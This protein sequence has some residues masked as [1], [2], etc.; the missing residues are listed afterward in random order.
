MLFKFII[1][2]DI[3]RSTIILLKKMPLI[4]KEG[5]RNQKGNEL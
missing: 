5:E 3:T 2:F 4:S 1:I